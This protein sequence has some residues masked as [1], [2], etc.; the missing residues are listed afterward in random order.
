MIF[1]EQNVLSGD[2][3]PLNMYGINLRIPQ[4]PCS[5]A[6]A[7]HRLGRIKIGTAYL[8]KYPALGFMG[9]NMHLITKEQ[10]Q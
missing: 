5:P 4:V 6:Y 3:T 10:A 9:S 8:C 7:Y 1:E 2:H